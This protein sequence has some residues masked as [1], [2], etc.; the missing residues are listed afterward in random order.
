MVNSRRASNRTGAADLQ[1]GSKTFMISKKLEYDKLKHTFQI[2]HLNVAIS[3]SNMFHWLNNFTTKLLKFSILITLY[4][5]ISKP[6][7][8]KFKVQNKFI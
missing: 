6:L 1:E 7:K 5:N 4:H 3:Y 8:L 2:Q